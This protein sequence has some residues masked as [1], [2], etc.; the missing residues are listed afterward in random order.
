MEKHCNRVQN[1]Q[2]QT[3][4]INNFDRAR[5]TELNCLR[6]QTSSKHLSLHDHRRVLSK[7]PQRKIDLMRLMRLCKHEMLSDAVICTTSAH[8]SPRHKHNQIKS[9]GKGEEMRSVF[10][11]LLLCFAHFASVHISHTYKICNFFIIIH[12]LCVSSF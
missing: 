5:F 3:T 6:R 2:T 9:F 11:S 4:Y 10:L 8:T 7:V 1:H 12:T